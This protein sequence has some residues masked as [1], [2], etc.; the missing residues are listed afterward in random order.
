[1]GQQILN[2][3]FIRDQFELLS[4]RPMLRPKRM[5]RKPG[6]MEGWKWAASK[7]VNFENLMNQQGFF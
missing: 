2:L 3:P 5:A 7:D 6:C 4:I 1:M